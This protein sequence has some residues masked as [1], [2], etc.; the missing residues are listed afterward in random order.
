VSAHAAFRRQPVPGQFAQQLKA[1]TIPA[2]TRGIIQSENDAFMGPGSCIISDNWFPTMKG[3]RLRGGC[4]RWCDLHALDAPVPPIGDPL[5][6]PVI[7]AFEYID[8][9]VQRMFAAQTTKLFDVT[10]ALPVLIA[11]GRTSGNYVASQL[12]NLAGNW[13]LICNETGDPV[14]RF[15]GTAWTTLT[16]EF[17]GGPV[18][19]TT[20]N[21][22][23]VCKYRS[24]FFFIETK[25]MNLWYL[26]IDS[27]QGALTK[28]PMSGAATRGGYLMSL[29]VWTIDAGDG[30]DDKLV[31]FT[32][33]GEALIF[34]GNDPAVPATWRQEGRYQVGKLMGMNAHTQIGGDVVILTVEGIVPLSQAIQKSAGE[35]ELALVSRAIKRM[36]REEVVDK[37]EWPWTIK[38]W[39]EYGGTF[40]TFPGGSPGAQYCLAMN[41]TTGS[42]ARAVGWDAMCFIR[43]RADLFFGTQAGLIMQAD[44]T[45]Y[46][47]GIP[48]VATLVG[49]WEMLQ[50]RAQMTHLRQARAVFTTSASEPFVPQLDATIDYIVTV[51]PPPQPG[52]DIGPADVWDETTWGP[53]MGGPPP[54]VPTTPQRIQ[55]GQWD[56]PDRGRPVNRNTMWV[57]IGKTGFSHAPI[58][59]VT[60]AQQARPD[61]ELVAIHAIFEQGGVNV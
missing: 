59:Q 38:K 18:P 1:I 8:A 34:T 56:Q 61:V 37:S 42:F 47:D 9:N 58:V 12:A 26:P 49:G 54:P 21:L 17:T 23:Y 39:D 13:M 48:Y 33:E 35:M 55:Y 36:W 50:A 40:V 52:P 14:M 22:S 45:G 29:A 19:G 46:D 4:I 60:V 24:R 51:P 41:S 57:S 25:S 53:D 16:T 15:D 32:S 43:L 10:A 28:I 11:S 3:V 27:H 31:A 5:R 6:K 44:R 2:P 20:Q 30:I 7:S